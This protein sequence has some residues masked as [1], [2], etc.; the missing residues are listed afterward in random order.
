VITAKHGQSPIDPSRYVSQ[1]INGTSP[2]TLLS[3]AGYIPNSESTNNSTGIGPTEDDVSLVWL[4]SSANTEASVKILEDNASAT[5]IALGQLYY[6]PSVALNF[7]DP[8][9]DP[10]TPDIIVT[11][12]VGVTYSGSKAKLSE[13][14]GFAHDDTNVVLLLSHPSFQART[15]TSVVGTAQVAPTILKALDLDPSQLFAVRVEGTSVLPG[16]KLSW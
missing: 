3:N 8:T 7:N 15:V 9:V 6:G 13:H 12:N 16:V 2:V 4:N 11:P 10:R 5:G 1:L 14:G